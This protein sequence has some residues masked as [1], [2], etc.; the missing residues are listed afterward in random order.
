MA[1][2]TCVFLREEFVPCLTATNMLIRILL[3]TW[4]D[5]L[6]LAFFDTE[7][8]T[9]DVQSLAVPTTSYTWI[10]RHPCIQ[11]HFYALEAPSDAKGTISVLHISDD[12][13][14][15]LQKLSLKGQDVE[16]FLVEIMLFIISS[17]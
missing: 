14:T 6:Q 1:V 8:N 7:Q 10:A 4:A 5:S 12:K 9:I 2:V 17:L 13:V 15:C 16:L 3:G 11:N